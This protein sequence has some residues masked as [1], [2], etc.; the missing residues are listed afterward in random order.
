M[1]DIVVRITSFGFKYGVPTDADFVFDVRN[2]PNPYWVEEMREM[3]G[4]DADVRKYVFRD[5][6]SKR[7]IELLF[8]AVDAYLKT[9]KR[10]EVNVYIGCTGGQHRSVACAIKLSEMI[11][12][13]GYPVWTSHR[14]QER[15]SHK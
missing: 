14:E 10:E 13:A 7:Y 12:D 1:S 11:R 4:L 9:T 15:F 6:G 2:L 5:D 3:S 8:G